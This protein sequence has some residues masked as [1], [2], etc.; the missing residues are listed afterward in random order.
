MVTILYF[1]WLRDRL[2]RSGE[3]IALP[4]GGCSVGELMQRLSVRDAAYGQ[5]FGPDGGPI[6]CAVNQEFASHADHVGPGDEL[7]FFPPVTGG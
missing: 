3:S 1:A 6:R 2:G 7:A 5:V 4:E